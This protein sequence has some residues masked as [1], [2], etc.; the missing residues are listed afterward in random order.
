MNT[1]I[2][3]DIY[4]GI[5]KIEIVGSYTFLGFILDQHLTFKEHI[6]YLAKQLSTIIYFMK[7]VS[8]LSTE[9]MIL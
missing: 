4:I 6:D 2:L 5:S 1:R 3:K 9:N 8:F 7:K